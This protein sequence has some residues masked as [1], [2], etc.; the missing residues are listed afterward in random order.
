MKKTVRGHQGDVQF[1][2]TSLPKGAVKIKNR[3]I[4]LGEFSGHM[5]VMTGDVELYEFEGKT[6]AVVGSDGACLQHVHDSN[7]KESMYGSKEKITIA[8]HKAIDLEA[9]T[10]EMVIQ[11]AY[12]PF[13]KIFEQVID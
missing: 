5:H 10:Y 11:N 3:P 7:F 13:K 4:A 2:T 12:N 8:D 1:S 9:G 6:F